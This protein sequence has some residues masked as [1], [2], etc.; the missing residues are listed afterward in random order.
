MWIVDGYCFDLALCM[1][2]Q[3]TR[4]KQNGITLVQIL[5]KLNREMGQIKNKTKREW[6]DSQQPIRK[7]PA[8]LEQVMGEFPV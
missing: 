7:A 4:P 3:Q 5:P 6:G 1:R 2:L 8:Y